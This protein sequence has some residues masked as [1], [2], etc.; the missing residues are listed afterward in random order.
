MKAMFGTCNNI[1]VTITTLDIIRHP[2][3]YLKHNVSETRFCLRLQVGTEGT[4]G[5]A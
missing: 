5:T 2:V 4:E 3:L 1:N